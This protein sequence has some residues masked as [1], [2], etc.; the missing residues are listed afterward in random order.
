MNTSY[1][2]SGFCIALPSN[3]SSIKAFPKNKNNLWTIVL[4][5]PLDMDGEWEMG[6]TNIAL[7]TES[8]LSEYLSI[9]RIT[10]VF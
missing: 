10:T 1:P 4:P 8:L 2:E 6:L 7:P 3:D 9:L 5:V